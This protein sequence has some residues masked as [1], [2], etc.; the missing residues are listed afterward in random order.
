M[1]SLLLFFATQRMPLPDDP[2]PAAVA[3]E[4]FDQAWIDT[5]KVVELKKAD[6]ERVASTT[7]KPIQTE[8]ILLPPPAAMPAVQMTEDDPPAKPKQIERDVCQ[9]HGMH[10]VYIR[11]GRSWR[12]RRA[13]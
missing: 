12:C 9:R 11:G 7:P 5:L 1:L 8:Q 4:L 6:M 2:I 13:P 10:K 3:D